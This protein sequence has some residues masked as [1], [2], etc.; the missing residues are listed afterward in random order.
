MKTVQGVAPIQMLYAALQNPSNM[1]YLFILLTLF[2]S[3]LQA[4][5]VLKFDKRFVES[6]DKWVAFQKGKDST[7]MYG[8]IYIDAQAGL[9]LN[10]E[11]NFTISEVGTFIPKKLDSTNFKI[12]LEP[13][14]VRVAFI[15]N[16]KFSELKISAIPEW[17]KYYKTDTA[18]VERLYR[19]G[20]MY[21]G[22]DECAKGLTYLER[23][24]KINPDFKGLAV[25]LAFSYNCL[26]QFD[27][28]ILVLQNAL[29]TNPTDAYINKELIYA[30]IKSGQLDNAAESCKKAIA[31]CTDKSYNGENCYNL[32]H[33]FYEKKDKTNFNLWLAE[34]KKWT[35]ANASMTRSIKIMEDELAK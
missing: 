10:Y 23:A 2:T 24:E 4:Q 18:S 25:E 1:K 13:N 5:S 31:V 20:F 17:L 27:K 15:P 9:T 22:W 6:E 14:R 34:T 28:A 26:N 29:A 32:L 19:W 3:T 21:N 30:Q 35:T 16:N 11:G 33:N 12:R 8:F 7:F